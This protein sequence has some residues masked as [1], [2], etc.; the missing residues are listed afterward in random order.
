MCVH[1][2]DSVNEQGIR[3]SVA[4]HFRRRHDTLVTMEKAARYTKNKAEDN[5]RAFEDGVRKPTKQ[6]RT[7]EDVRAGMPDTE[8]IVAL[9]AKLM[10]DT[11][12]FTGAGR[13]NRVFLISTRKAFI[14]QDMPRFCANN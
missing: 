10:T 8:A 9:N 4:R 7:R 6:A 3:D 1:P 12:S 13:N 11:K 5:G 14:C 2:F